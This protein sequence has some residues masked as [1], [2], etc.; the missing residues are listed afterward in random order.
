M[1]QGKNDR[2]DVAASDKNGR[3]KKKK[4][5]CSLENWT[6]ISRNRAQP[7]SLETTEKNGFS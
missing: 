6:C 2:A 4:N 5:P 1:S 7:E 3:K